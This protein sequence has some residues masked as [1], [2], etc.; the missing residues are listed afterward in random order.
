MRNLLLFTLL[1]WLG[2]ETKNALAPKPDSKPALASAT[3]AAPQPVILLT[4]PSGSDTFIK[5]DTASLSRFLAGYLHA[6]SEFTALCVLSDS[7]KQCPYYSGVIRLD[8]LAG[9]SNFVVD[10]QHRLENQRRLAGANQLLK[11]VLEQFQRKYLQ[12]PKVPKSDVANALRVVSIAASNKAYAN[13]KVIVIL[14]CDLLQD[15]IKYQAESIQPVQFPPNVQLVLIGNHP[16]V[17]LE[18][19][20]PG[21]NPIQLT[22]FQHLQTLTL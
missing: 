7:Y 16:S 2:C 3:P 21:Q 6:G 17:D 14:A 9:S 13:R 15:L 12:I 11:P 22:S 19:L 1:L 8:T 4:D 20:F 5:P 18:Y 10:R